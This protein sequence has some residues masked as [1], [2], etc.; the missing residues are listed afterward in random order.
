M[1]AMSV[2]FASMMKFAKSKVQ[3][4]MADTNMVTRAIVS[5]YPLLRPLILVLTL[6]KPETKVKLVATTISGCAQKERL[7]DEDSIYSYGKRQTNSKD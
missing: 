6:H 5:K 7:E 1:F 2:I 3:R 4:T